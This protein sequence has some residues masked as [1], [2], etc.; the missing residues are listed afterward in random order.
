M[1]KVENNAV[2]GKING[3][4]TVTEKV[5]ARSVEETQPAAAA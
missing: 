4:A 3:E 5:V 2:A 1:K